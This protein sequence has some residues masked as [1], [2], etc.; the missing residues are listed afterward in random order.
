M[1]HNI[2]PIDSKNSEHEL[3][4]WLISIWLGGNLFKTCRALEVGTLN[5]I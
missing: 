2:S 5:V 4:A 1:E 3:K